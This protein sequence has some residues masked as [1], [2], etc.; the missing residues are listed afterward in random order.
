MKLAS[1]LSG[2]LHRAERKPEPA[3]AAGERLGPPSRAP[4]EP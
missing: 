4:R 1:T 3:R 2:F